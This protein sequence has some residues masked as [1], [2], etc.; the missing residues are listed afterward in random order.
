MV[1]EWLFWQVGG[2]GPMCGQAHHFRNYAP[3][4]IQYGID[5]YTNEVNRLYGVMEVRLRKTP[6]LAGAYSIADMAAYPWVVPYKNQ[7][8]DLNEFPHLRKWFDGMKE[9]PAVRRAIESGL[10]M[11]GK[12]QEDIRQNA[13]VQKI[14]F[15]QRARI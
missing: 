13:E 15:G 10:E 9:R 1:N 3:E 11:R 2:L 14:L 5:R 4:K 6:F 7:G 8:Q 12:V